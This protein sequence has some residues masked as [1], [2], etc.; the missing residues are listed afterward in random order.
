MSCYFLQQ[1]QFCFFVKHVKIQH[2]AYGQFCPTSSNSSFESFFVL[3]TDQCLKLFVTPL[4]LLKNKN[5]D[6]P[7][8]MLFY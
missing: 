1:D 4:T 6:L 8:V 3:S 7:G 2:T 5:L